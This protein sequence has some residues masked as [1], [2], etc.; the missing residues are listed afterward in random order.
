MGGG[1]GRLTV[2]QT[3]KVEAGCAIFMDMNCKA[4]LSSARLDMT[5]V[6]KLGQPRAIYPVCSP[7]CCVQDRDAVWR[8]ES[9]CDG[10]ACSIPALP[11][12]QPTFL[13]DNQRV[14]CHVS[15]RLPAEDR[16]APGYR[17][18]PVY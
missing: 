1:L 6:A 7:D 5:G 11:A 8:A 15:V 13:F 4:Y 9:L 3:K 2:T 12:R 18:P 17:T 10:A 16:P 14:G